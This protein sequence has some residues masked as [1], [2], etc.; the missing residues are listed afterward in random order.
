MYEVW[1][2]R[3]KGNTTGA[4]QP[5]DKQVTEWSTDALAT[6]GARARGPCGRPRRHDGV[7]RKAW[8]AF[9]TAVL[10]LFLPHSTPLL[11]SVPFALAK[12]L[13]VRIVHEIIRAKV[14]GAVGQRGQRPVSELEP[15]WQLAIVCGTVFL[16]R[17]EQR[18]EEVG[19]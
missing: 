11:G 13:H 2:A 17:G 6:V 10:A 15:T 7:I 1:G 18:F 5:A 19:F 16:D 8:A 14:Q 12:P 9:A 4:R 3:G